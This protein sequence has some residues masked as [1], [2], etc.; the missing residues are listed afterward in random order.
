VEPSLSARVAATGELMARHGYVPIPPFDDRAVIAGQ[1]TVGLE[2][3]ADRPRADLVV[4]PVSGGG[5]ISGIAA[6]IRTCCPGERA[7]SAPASCQRPR[8]R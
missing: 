8:C 7:C 2:I 6:A 3:A 5:L 1:G 4:V